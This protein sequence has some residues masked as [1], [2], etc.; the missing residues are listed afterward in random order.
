MLEDGVC[1]KIKLIEVK[2]GASLS[3]QMRHHRSEHWVVLSGAAKVFNCE[4]EIFINTNES[5]HIT[6]GH[7]HCLTNPGTETCVMIEVQSVSYLDEDDVVRFQDS[8]GRALNCLSH[9]VPIE[10]LISVVSSEN[11]NPSTVYL[12]GAAWRVVNLVQSA[13]VKTVRIWS[14]TTNGATW[15]WFLT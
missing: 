7:K 14:T 6:A 2:P 4:K 5:T 10:A 15:R 12:L 3:L 8:Y 11:S 13:L 1:F 9:Y